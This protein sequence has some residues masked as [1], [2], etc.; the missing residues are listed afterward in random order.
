VVK[1]K[2]EATNE[3]VD[4]LFGLTED[5]EI[6]LRIKINECYQA[7]KVHEDLACQ[8]VVNCSKVAVGVARHKTVIFTLFSP[9]HLG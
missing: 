5:H 1:S 7:G 6:W 2:K 9:T 4:F 8:A 3:S